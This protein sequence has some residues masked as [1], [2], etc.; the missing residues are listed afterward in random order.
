[1]VQPLLLPAFH[2]PNDAS[3]ITQR[4]L[5][6]KRISK[7]SFVVALTL[8]FSPWIFRA[9]EDFLHPCAHLMEL[10]PWLSDT[11]GATLTP[12]GL[13]D[14]GAQSIFGDA[15]GLHKDTIFSRVHFGGIFPQ[16]FPNSTL[17]WPI[18]FSKSRADPTQAAPGN[19]LPEARTFVTSVKQSGIGEKNYRSV[20][21]CFPGCSVPCKTL[22]SSLK[23][24]LFSGCAPKAAKQ[25]FTLS[26]TDISCSDQQDLWAASNTCLKT[27][28]LGLVT[29]NRRVAQLASSWEQ[30]I[31]SF[32][33][34][35]FK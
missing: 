11:Y 27:A 14:S 34:P 18:P 31:F 7:L 35:S 1:M 22:G 30:D 20:E 6:A 29:Q 3:Q 26:H 2:S 23:T 8:K 12:T 4:H 25:I 15:P 33:V 32:L 9:A 19:P 16:H 5:P 10:S 24:S 17:L 13:A 21:K 28:W